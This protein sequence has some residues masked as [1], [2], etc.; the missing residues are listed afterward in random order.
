MTLEGRVCNLA[1]LVDEFL[2]ERHGPGLR[3]RMAPQTFHMAAL[4]QEMQDIEKVYQGMPQPGDCAA[5]PPSFIIWVLCLVAS[6]DTVTCS[7]SS[8]EGEKCCVYFHRLHTL[9]A[10]NP[11]CYGAQVFMVS[12][13]NLWKEPSG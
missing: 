12:H 8:Y 10:W 7:A 5:S 13:C 4:L 9:L 1:Q 2:A 11:L 3:Q 6:N